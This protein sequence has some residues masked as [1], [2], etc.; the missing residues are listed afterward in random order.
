MNQI[1]LITCI[2]LFLL[3][4]IVLMGQLRLEGV[5][6]D[7]KGFPLG[8]A[9]V[10]LKNSGTGVITNPDG[11]YELLL[12]KSQQRFTII[13]SFLGYET[14]EEIVSFF[15]TETI[16]LNVSL[17]STAV[18]IV[19]LEIKADRRSD[20][21]SMTRL[22]TFQVE[23]LPTAGAGG[24]EALIKT[25]PGVSSN[26][27]LS[28]QYSVRGGNFDENLVYVND[29][30]I[31]RPFLVRSGQ[32]EGL[33]FIN[34]DMVSNISFSAG[35]F[36][37]RYGDKL[38]SVLDIE[39]KRP[40]EFEAGVGLSLLGT[41]AYVGGSNKSRRLSYIVGARHRTN[42]YLLNSLPTEGGYE[43][44]FVDLQGFLTFDINLNW[45]WQLIANYSQNRYQFR[46]NSAIF[47]FGEIQNVKRL[48]I[49][50]EGQEKD[51]YIAAMG[52]TG[53]VYTSD[54]EDLTL[55][56]LASAFT[57]TEEENFDIIGE[58]FLGEVESDQG[59]ENF[60]EV[61]SEYGI[62]TYH[63]YARNEL[64]ALIGN[65]AHKGYYDK[66]DHFINWGV[67]YQYE[68]ITDRLNEWQRVDSAGY[69][70]S[71]GESIFSG[72]YNPL[73][74]ELF[75]VKKT[76]F[77]LQSHRITTFVQDSWDFGEKRNA[78]LTAGARLNYWSV[79]KELFVVPRVQL[80][81]QPKVDSLA[82]AERFDAL[83]RG[84]PLPPKNQTSYRIAAG[85]YHQP[86]FYRE[87]R[88]F[89]G[90]VNTDLKSQK[91]AHFV[92]GLDHEFTMW[93]R[94]FKFTGEAYFKYFWDLVPYD[95][96]NV[97][98]RY[99]G[100]N[101]AIGYSTGLDFRLN[102]E[103]VP[104]TESWFSLSILQT[105]EDVLDDFFTQYFNS[106]GVEVPP[107]ATNQI[108]DSLTTQRGFIPRPTDQIVNFAIFFQDNLPNNEN[109][110][111]NLNV[112]FG[113]PLP[114]GP[115]NQA[116]NRNAL[117]FALPYMRVDIGFSAQLFER[118]KREIPINSWLN[119]FESLWAAVEVF[120]LIDAPNIISHSW[121]NDFTGQF[122]SVPNRLTNRRVNARLIMKF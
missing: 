5:V 38:S 31:Y 96:D 14:V 116:R 118:G 54:E 120:N 72:G 39:Y 64:Q 41:N 42:K 25:L 50:Y 40:R 74:V 59:D 35:A 79:N 43:P 122:Y 33:S 13:Y 92:A 44:L 57:T 97:L 83:E 99:Y 81:W 114:Y 11:S 85:M 32:Q 58:Y 48:R 89:A 22:S 21:G 86:P 12:P 30:E 113:S 51:E 37:A 61:V 112:L 19:E 20:A 101:N 104:G 76:D 95:V 93:E 71:G 103:F 65:I 4:S 108:V 1:K 49:A 8:G 52:G 98:I 70:L 2:G 69:S 111:A 36:E 119:G 90:K 23:Q 18:D 17:Q 109:I 10:S 67:K 121:I 82:E 115:P 87:M 117:R 105:R 78:I 47:Q 7:T 88:N 28:S 91:S 60:G 68:D 27:E 106:E 63:D 75:S 102:G 77:D 34:S 80:S 66:G 29:F 3:S 62:G 45:Q 53:F 100:E 55:K 16:T 46:P 107:S 94:P 26:N 56:F 15:N 73:E 24:V 84:E 9:N 6:S 110:K